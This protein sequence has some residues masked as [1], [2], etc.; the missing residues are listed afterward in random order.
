MGLGGA[1]KRKQEPPLVPHTNL[2][3]TQMSVCSQAVDSYSGSSCLQAR[4]LS[5]KHPACSG[6]HLQLPCAAA[7]LLVTARGAMGR[8]TAS[9]ASSAASCPL[10]SYT[11]SLCFHQHGRLAHQTPFYIDFVRLIPI[12]NEKSVLPWDLLKIN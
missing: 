5:T 7:L 11:Q 9:P 10:G 12:T 2:L 3:S 1:G 8:N 6:E 4:L